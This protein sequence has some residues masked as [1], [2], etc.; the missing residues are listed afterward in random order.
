MQL[1]EI[2]DA[3]QNFKSIQVIASSEGIEIAKIYIENGVQKKYS[4]RLYYNILESQNVIEVNTVGLGSS[5][6]LSV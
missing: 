3:D 2:Q 1:P 4:D 5:V 6:T